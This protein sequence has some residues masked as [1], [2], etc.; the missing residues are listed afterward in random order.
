M[1]KTFY[2]RVRHFRNCIVAKRI[3]LF[4]EHQ[5][6]IKGPVIKYVYWGVEDIP[7]FYP[8]IWQPPPKK[9]NI[10]KYLIPPLKGD[11]MFHTPLPTPNQSPSPQKH[12]ILRT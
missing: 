9:K 1:P 4:P 3:S 6:G 7:K 10:G 11:G 8:K 5:S 2:R 12:K